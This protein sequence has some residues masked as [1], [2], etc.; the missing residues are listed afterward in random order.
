[1]TWEEQNRPPYPVGK[2]IWTSIK[3]P[4]GR[5]VHHGLRTGPRGDGLLY[6]GGCRS[7]IPAHRRPKGPFHVDGV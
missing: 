5:L 2:S 4:H 3:Y 7:G 6:V 1:M